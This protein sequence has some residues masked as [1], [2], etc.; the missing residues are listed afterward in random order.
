MMR[1]QSIDRDP[2]FGARTI[3]CRAIWSLGDAFFPLNIGSD[4]DK[5]DG[6]AVAEIL[7][8]QKLTHI[9]LKIP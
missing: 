5:E 7:F 8:I 6:H 9:V 2:L 4:L 1:K 3:E